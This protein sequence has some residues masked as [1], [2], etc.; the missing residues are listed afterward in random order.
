[1]SPKE[2]PIDRSNPGGSLI[3]FFGYETGHLAR[4][5]FAL[6]YSRD[7]LWLDFGCGYGYGTW[8][9]SAQSSGLV[10]GVD[11]DRRAIRYARTHFSRPNLRFV[12]YEGY[13]EILARSSVGLIACFEVLEHLY[14]EQIEEFLSTADRVLLPGSVIV[15]STPNAELGHTD[16]H[17]FHIHEYNATEICALASKHG[18]V[19]GLFGQGHADE[20]MEGLID[21]TINA[22]PR[23]LKRAY[24]LKIGQSLAFAISSRRA[25]P[26]APRF[27][28]S[29]FNPE[30]SSTMV[31]VLR[32]ASEL[33]VDGS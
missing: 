28:V 31:F 6:K 5:L 20:P 26:S 18:F 17:V 32:K 16:D 2:R 7:G 29:E 33:R 22:I 23:P 21:R 4:Y 12:S 11:V 25:D 30:K 13:S 10:I 8:V 9:L 27:A 19:A 14:P 3:P 15:G 1:M 24:F